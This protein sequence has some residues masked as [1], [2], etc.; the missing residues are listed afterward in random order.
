MNFRILRIAILIALFS[1]IL[2]SI[3]T[4]EAE[5]RV[6]Y[7]RGRS[8]QRRHSAFSIKSQLELEELEKAREQIRKLMVERTIYDVDIDLEET[9]NGY[10]IVV[11]N[12]A[13]PESLSSFLDPTMIAL[14]VGAWYTKKTGWQSDTLKI[15]VGQGEGWGI[16]TKDCRI[17]EARASTDFW[18]IRTVDPYVL[19][20]QMVDKFFLLKAPFLESKGME[21]F[22]IFIFCL[23]LFVIGGIIGK[24]GSKIFYKA[25]QKL[26]KEEEK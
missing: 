25:K 4:Q 6:P 18:F 20:K 1:D 17:A 13:E 23:L 5:A 11:I 22:Q 8:R 12:R 26:K 2:L 15:W 21:K 3:N 14:I 7:R 24:Y 10:N 16:L 9:S 19:R